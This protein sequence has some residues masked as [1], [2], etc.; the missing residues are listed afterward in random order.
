MG[1]G[2]QFLILVIHLSSPIPV[3][4][5]NFNPL[6]LTQL[7]PPKVAFEPDT[8]TVKMGFLFRKVLPVLG[9]EIKQPYFDYFSRCMI[10]HMIRPVNA[11]LAIAALRSLTLISAPR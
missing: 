1:S 11:N 4:L 8:L 3:Q 7:N 5:V 9:E 2:S 6:Y 10:R